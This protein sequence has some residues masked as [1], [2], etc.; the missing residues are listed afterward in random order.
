MIHSPKS[1]K[2]DGMYESK[3]YRHL[4][5]KI[6]YIWISE[7]SSSF[8]IVDSELPSGKYSYVGKLDTG[9]GWSEIC[10]I[11]DQIRISDEESPDA[12]KIFKQQNCQEKIVVI[13]Q[14]YGNPQNFIEELLEMNYIVTVHPLDIISKKNEKYEFALI[15][16]DSASGAFYL[17]RK[18]IL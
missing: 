16:G 8:S 13:P 17:I 14:G 2:S 5:G 7:N 6:P 11:G 12:P 18:N 15:C 4:S 9:I 10:N 1:S 3:I